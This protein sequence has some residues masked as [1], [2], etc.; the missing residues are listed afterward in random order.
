MIRPWVTSPEES[1]AHSRQTLDL[2]FEF[3]DFMQSIDIMAD[4]GCGAGLDL[5]WWATR[6]TRDES[7]RPL[8]IRCVG[9][10]QLDQLPVAHKYRNITYQ[11]RDFEREQ[12]HS[13]TRVFDVMWCHDSFQYV[14]EPLR[15]LPLWRLSLAENGMLVIIVPQTTNIA[16]RRQDFYQRDF[17]YH[18]WTLVSLI[19]IL[20]VSGFD[21]HDAYFRKLPDDAWLHVVVYRGQHE[22]LDARRTT[23]YDLCDLGVLPESAARSILRH[24]HLRQQ[25]LVLPWLDRSMM[26][27]ANH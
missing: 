20:A 17:C 21:C 27:F 10:D 26:T 8:N 16:G 11:Q 24:G 3:D 4:I 2:L 12:L 5:E 18:H 13:G 9:I 23:W 7:P 14:T 1:H 25:D 15:V 6:T 19:H 22:P